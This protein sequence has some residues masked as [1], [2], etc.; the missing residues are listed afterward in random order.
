MNFM[1]LVPIECVREN[2]ILGKT[3]YDEEGRILLQS[4]TKLTRGII[5]TMI[6][7]K[8][9][10]LYIDD[11]YTEEE[12]E[13]IIRPQIRKKST[14]VIKETFTSIERIYTKKDLGPA[15]Y[16]KKKNKIYFSSIYKVAQELLDEILKNNKVLSS[17][18]DIKSM[19]NYTYEHTINVAVIS[20]VIG[21]SLKFNREEL[22]NIALGALTHD[23]GKSF[24]PKEITKKYY[25]LN[26]E[27][28]TVYRQHCLRGYEYLDNNFN[29]PL[30]SMLPALEHHEHYDGTGYP[31][32]VKGDNIHINSRIIAIANCYDELTS[33]TK[34]SRGICAN[35][36]IEYIMAQGGKKF[37]FELVNVFSHVII[38]YPKGTL[39]RLS[40][41]EIAIVKYTPPNYP[42]RPKV[43][44]IKSTDEKRQGTT[45]DLIKELSLVIIQ[46]EYGLC[47]A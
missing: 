47:S 4:G 13:E 9:F 29:L 39:V 33:D 34:D 37:D 15:S 23:I 3:I 28:K 20:I 22:I 36:A 8:I 31:K 43:Q 21:I 16:W 40:N 18:V 7:I 32:G 26:D 42:L 24:I 44:I 27:E 45:I 6:S 25:K 17:L 19:D 38:P 46:I 10:S 5:E 14:S 2:S 1:R 35:D 11:S 30:E 41:N 12:I